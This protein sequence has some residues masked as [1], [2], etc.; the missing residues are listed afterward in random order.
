MWRNHTKH[1]LWKCGGQW[2]FFHG[3]ANLRSSGSIESM[4]W[5]NHE[6][7][8][9]L[10]RKWMLAMIRREPIE[11]YLTTGRTNTNGFYTPLEKDGDVLDMK[12]V[13]KLDN[14]NE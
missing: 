6:G 4:S 14:G 10:N 3:S 9:S 7:L 1:A 11:K 8:Y 13:R 5:Y 12:K 2:F